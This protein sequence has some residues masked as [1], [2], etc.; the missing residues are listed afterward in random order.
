M[1]GQVVIVGEFRNGRVQ[2]S[3]TFDRLSGEKIQRHEIVYAVECSATFGTVLIHRCL[4][5]DLDVA[6]VEIG[7][8]KGRRYAFELDWFERKNSGV[9]AQL[10]FREPEL[11]E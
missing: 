1:N 9:Y 10:S 7:L 8:L 2:S 5:A 3:D 4:P 11:L 6:K